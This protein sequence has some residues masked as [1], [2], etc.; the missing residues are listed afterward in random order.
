MSRMSNGHMSAFFL[1]CATGAETFPNQTTAALVSLKDKAAAPRNNPTAS[2]NEENASYYNSAA[3]RQQCRVNQARYRSRKRKAQEQLGID[4]QNLRQEVNSLKRRYRDLSSRERS[5]HSPWSI[6]AE[7]F[8]LLQSSFRSPW[9]MSSAREMM[10]NPETQRTLAVLE[11]SFA[12]DAA[13]GDLRG[14]KALLDQL[15]LYLQCFGGSQLRLKRIETMSAGV[16]AARAELRA[17]VT[18][19]TLKHVF[20]HLVSD[21]NL[22]TDEKRKRLRGRLLG[23]RLKVS[24]TIT[25]LFDDI[26]RRVV[27]LEVNADLVTALQQVFGSLG[28]VS[29]VLERSLITPDFTIGTEEPFPSSSV[30]RT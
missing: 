2:S 6:V 12:L 1:S 28:D 25:F 4:V 3:R 14:V 18:E 24:C 9:R 29:L 22:I 8:H 27:R 19:A 10:I 20:P 11:R 17:T 15:Q 13:M 7:V 16:M 23:Q 21:D 26:S 30:S 5:S